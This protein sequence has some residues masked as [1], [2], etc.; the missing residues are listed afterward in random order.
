MNIKIQKNNL[1]FIT[2]NFQCINRALQATGQNK[3]VVFTIMTSC[4][5]LNNYND[6]LNG[7]ILPLGIVYFEILRPI[8]L[9]LKD[10]KSPF[11][12]ISATNERW[13][14]FFEKVVK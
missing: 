13:N 12:K 14:P 1:K 11:R 9:S 3:S 4:Y 6:Y 10:I 2:T 7:D 5:Q 8:F